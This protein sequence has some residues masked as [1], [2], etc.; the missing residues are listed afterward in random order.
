MADF[1]AGDRVVKM[2][3]TGAGKYGTV[4]SVM[5]NG[6]LNVTFDGERL[7]RYC[8]PM[9]CGQVATNAKFS[10]GTMLDTGIKV[11]K[12]RGLFGDTSHIGKVGTAVRVYDE[13]GEGAAVMVRYPGSTELFEEDSRTLV[14]VNSRAANAATPTGADIARFW[15]LAKAYHDGRISA[16]QS[17]ELNVLED[18]FLWDVT[19]V[20]PRATSWSGNPPKVSKSPWAHES[21]SAWKNSE[22]K[23]RVRNERIRAYPDGP[24]EWIL[25]D[26][27]GD[28]GVGR[29]TATD[30]RGIKAQLADIAVRTYRWHRPEI[31]IMREKYYS[32]AARNS[33]ALNWNYRN[34][35]QFFCVDP[36]MKAPCIYS[37]WDYRE[38]AKDDAEELKELGIPHKIVSRRFLE[39][40]G[41]DPNDGASWKKNRGVNAARNDLRHDK[42]IAKAGRIAAQRIGQLESEFTELFRKR[43]A[44][45][46]RRVRLTDAQAQE[47]KTADVRAKASYKPGIFPSVKIAPVSRSKFA[48][49]I[50]MAGGYFGTRLE[51]WLESV[52]KA[53]GG[54]ASDWVSTS[55]WATRN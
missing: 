6:T 24:G 54:W 23:S 13:G 26:A 18:K 34:S 48:E 4:N 8:D 50:A 17:H 38:D 55:D 28:E 27:V 45:Y 22:R 9:R 33:R 14:R 40:N 1:K 53:A 20:N 47:L 44:D 51:R 52:W 11:K 10:D 32:N 2:S 25:V 41:I 15:K 42:I 46:V 21:W 16:S 37:G 31:V 49:E 12:T 7:P 30:E 3:G 36:S 5:D 43:I 35:Y 19:D 39:Q 29:T